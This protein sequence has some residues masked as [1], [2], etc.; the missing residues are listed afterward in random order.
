MS[1][2]RAELRNS[3]MAA[4]DQILNERDASSQDAA[5]VKAANDAFDLIAVILARLQVDINK[6]VAS[7][8]NA[9]ADQL[10]KSIAA[11]RA[12]G[13]SVAAKTI[14]KT[15]AKLPS[16]SKP[17]DNK[18]QPNDKQPTTQPDKSQATAG[19]AGGGPT[20]KSPQ[21]GSTP[22]GVV[23]N[24]PK[25]IPPGDPAPFAAFSPSIASTYWPIVSAAEDARVVSYETTSG[26]VIGRP[27]RCFLAE[28]NGGE[29]NHVGVDLFAAE[30][31]LIVA[32]TDGRILNFYKF[33]NSKGRDTYALILEH[34][35]VVINYGEVAPD[36]LDEFKL[37][38]NDSVKAG[39]PIGRVGATAMLHFETY[40]LGTT[41]NIRWMAGDPKPAAVQNP[42]KL[43]LS[44]AAHG[45]SEALSP[46][47]A[48]DRAVADRIG[49]VAGAALDGALKP[50]LRTALRLH[51]I[52]DASPY[53]LSF[54]SKGASGASFG[55]MQGDLAAGQP[56]VTRTF[57]DVLSAANFS[58][59][60]IEQ[61]TA[62]L[63]VHLVG[64]PLS[65]VDTSAINSALLASK[66]LVDA[67][68][69]MIFAGVCR[70]LQQ[71]I[72]TAAKAGR[73]IA[74]K[75]LIYMALWINMTGPPTKLLTWLTGNDPGF[76]QAV[77]QAGK[78][79]DGAAIEN[80]LRATSYYVS[81]PGN[82]PHLQQCAA[83]GAAFLVTS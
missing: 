24:V 8:L 18:P 83:A 6:N 4:S 53:Q 26:A 25:E 69:E 48:P 23:D 31:D 42:T 47:I 50:A 61:L 80:Y 13:L 46:A 17:A 21:G 52:G 74:P 15:L 37:R 76:G 55:F 29:R 54:A 27:G 36:S 12:V 77:P 10:R 1:D 81:N 70:D 82:F 62:K 34:P 30:G 63:S 39:Q 64:N 20:P 19:A 45:A 49:T 44:L 58:E 7:D 59:Q 35:G 68:D 73:C 57:H 79:V 3:L 67:M 60:R 28:R 41:Q 5:K 72:D 38:I 40:A 75:A 33:Y 56:E 51:E 16:I 32:C 2:D 14:E 22:A 9:V 71:C 78:L 43:L 11:Q 65:A 66:N